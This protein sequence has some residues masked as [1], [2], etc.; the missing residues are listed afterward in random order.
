MSIINMGLEKVVEKA[1]KRRE[2]VIS[3]A[4]HFGYVYEPHIYSAI[5]L[6]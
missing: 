4:E 2:N 6:K 1:R 3:T 5:I